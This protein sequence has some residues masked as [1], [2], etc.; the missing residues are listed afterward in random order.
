MEGG[1]RCSGAGSGG[2][3][4]VGGVGGDIWVPDVGRFVRR[5][6]SLMWSMSMEENVLVLYAR[7]KQLM[8][9]SPE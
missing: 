6:D 3:V 7:L 5:K 1:I 4:Q 2:V 9:R 8:K